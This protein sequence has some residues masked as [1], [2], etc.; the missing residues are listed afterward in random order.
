MFCKSCRAH[1]QSVVCL[2]L[3]V[4][5]GGDVVR[6]QTSV[7]AGRREKAEVGPTGWKKR[8]LHLVRQE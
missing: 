2:Y 1:V 7:R 6:Q 4:T 8:G 3:S 5:V